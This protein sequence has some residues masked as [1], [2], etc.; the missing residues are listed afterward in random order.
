ME[1]AE[2]PQSFSEVIDAIGISKLADA[3]AEK[4]PTVAAWKRRNSI[5]SRAWRSIVAAAARP[6]ITLDL[7][8]SFAARHGSPPRRDQ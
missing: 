8:A 2:T 3:A 6:D 7:L 1:H 4:Y 5:P